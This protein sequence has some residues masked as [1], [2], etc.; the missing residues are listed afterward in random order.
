M[1]RAKKESNE[2]KETKKKAVDSHGKNHSYE[3]CGIPV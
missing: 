1:P 2:V 3:R